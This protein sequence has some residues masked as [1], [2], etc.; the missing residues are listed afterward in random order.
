MRSS[1]TY[2]IALSQKFLPPQTKTRIIYRRLGVKSC[3]S[4]A[5]K[6]AY[7]LRPLEATTPGSSPAVAPISSITVISAVKAASTALHVILS[8]LDFLLDAS[9]FLTVEQPFAPVTK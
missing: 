6:T 7:T 8:L 3:E 1:V 9:D 5:A 4:E 2:S